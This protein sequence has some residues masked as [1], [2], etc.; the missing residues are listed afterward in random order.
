MWIV[1]DNE[2]GLMCMTVDRNEALRE[3][4]RCKESARDYVDSNGEFD[5]NESVILAK[6]EKH[7]YSYDTG[8]LVI[9]EDEDGKE[10]ETK[11]TYWD[12]KEDAY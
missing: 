9:V 5:S 2:Y 12:W 6:V 3:Y 1:W 8:R 10:T 11:D 7:F 4:E